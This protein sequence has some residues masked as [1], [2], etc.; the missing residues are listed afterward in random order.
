LERR[1]HKL[2]LAEGN[3]KDAAKLQK[4]IERKCK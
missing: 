2:I 1:M 3:L 4:M